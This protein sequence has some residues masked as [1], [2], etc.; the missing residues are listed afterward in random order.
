M[1]V[2]E[3]ESRYIRETLWFQ[4]TSY[5]LKQATMKKHPPT[6]ALPD[7]SSAMKNAIDACRQAGLAV[8]RTST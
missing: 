5:A 1:R 2:N 8:V 6:A 4:V 3:L 7:R